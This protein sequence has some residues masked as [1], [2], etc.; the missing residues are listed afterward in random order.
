MTTWRYEDPLH[1]VGYSLE[2]SFVHPSSI[3]DDMN[4]IQQQMT[5][6]VFTCSEFAVEKF[7]GAWLHCGVYQDAEC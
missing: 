1:C 3:V 2:R 6:T 5:R 7:G 4:K